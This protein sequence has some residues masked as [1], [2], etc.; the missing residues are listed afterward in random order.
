M[1]D[2]STNISY[3]ICQDDECGKLTCTS[4]KTLLDGI[5]GHACEQNEDYKKFRKTATEKG[6]QE[7]PE[8]G[9]T[10]E[11]AEACNHIKYV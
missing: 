2:P 1:E 6:F 9:T 8:C 3:A 5:E 10:V 7:C 11:L 4:C